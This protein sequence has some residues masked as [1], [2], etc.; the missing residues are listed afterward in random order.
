[1]SGA[2]GGAILAESDI[3]DIVNGVFDGPVTAAKGLDLSGAHFGGGATGEEDFGFFGDASA[4]EMMG[5][6][7]DHSGLGGVR[8]SRVLG[9]DFEGIDLPG[10]MPAVAL[11]EGDV[12]REKKRRS[13]P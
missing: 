10:F 1:M 12:R 8:E 2:D 4:L 13:R 5:G 3:T 9:S 7:V 6:A 11:V